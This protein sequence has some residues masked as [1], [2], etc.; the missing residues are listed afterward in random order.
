MNICVGVCIKEVIKLKMALLR[1]AFYCV[2]VI[3]IFGLT[4]R[5]TR[6][7][8]R[9]VVLGAGWAGGGVIIEKNIVFVYFMF[10]IMYIILK[11]D[12]KIICF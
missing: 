5:I 8:C 2:A 12:N 10:Q 4:I 3:L 1:T 9:S 6:G 7:T 11:K